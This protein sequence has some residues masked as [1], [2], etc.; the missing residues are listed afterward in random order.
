MKFNREEHP[1]DVSM[2]L[3]SVLEHGQS[4]EAQTPIQRTVRVGNLLRSAGSNSGHL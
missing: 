3:N 4:I 2:L 1:L